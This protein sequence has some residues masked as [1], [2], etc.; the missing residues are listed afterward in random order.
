MISIID[1]F[2][3]KMYYLL[4]LLTESGVHHKK[5]SNNIVNVLLIDEFWTESARHV[6]IQL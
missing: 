3:I 4:D 1:I 5:Y 2:C 6:N